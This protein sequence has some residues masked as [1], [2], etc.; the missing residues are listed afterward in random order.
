MLGKANVL[1]RLA[2]CNI[3]IRQ[4]GRSLPCTDPSFCSF[5][6]TLLSVGKERI[7]GTSVGHAE[8]KPADS[9]DPC[10]NEDIPFASLNGVESHADGL[11]RGRAV[12]VDRDSRDVWHT[13]QDSHNACQ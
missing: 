11:Q 10:G 9:L 6:S 4:P 7:V 5:S 1:C 3:D 12:A 13:C 2:H 8:F